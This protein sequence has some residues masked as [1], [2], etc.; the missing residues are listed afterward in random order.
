MSTEI[1]KFE[2]LNYGQ[3]FMFKPEGDI[4]MRIPYFVDSISYKGEF[5]VYNLSNNI[6]GFALPVDNVIPLKTELVI[7]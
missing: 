6:Y 3:V 1:K 4:Y 5:N 7:H 2:D